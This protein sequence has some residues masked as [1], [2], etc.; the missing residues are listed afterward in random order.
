M[1]FI[2]DRVHLGT[3]PAISFADLVK[4]ASAPPKTLDQLLAEAK[5]A[6]DAPVKVAS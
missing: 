3:A 6:N 5:A 4:R 1:K 2:T